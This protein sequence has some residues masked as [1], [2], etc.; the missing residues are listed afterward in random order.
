MNAQREKAKRTDKSIVAYGVEQKKKKYDELK[1]AEQA[2]GF[3]HMRNDAF[4]FTSSKALIN[5]FRFESPSETY[6]KNSMHKIVSLFIFLIVIIVVQQRMQC[7]Y[8]FYYYFP[9]CAKNAI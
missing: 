9:I 3:A 8:T 5:T 4:C 1:H 2:S 6:T 7:F